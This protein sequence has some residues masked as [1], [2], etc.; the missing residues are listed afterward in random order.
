MGV[1]EICWVIYLAGLPFSNFLNKSLDLWHGH[2]TW[3]EIWLPVLVG[4]TFWSPTPNRPPN[5]ALG[6][7]I[8]V[9]GVT[10][11]GLWYVL[12]GQAKAYPVSLLMPMLHL[13]SALLFVWAAWQ[14]WTRQLVPILLTW[15][16]RVG[17][18]SVCYGL[19]QVA[20]LDQFF[21][22]ISANI[23]RDALVGTIGNYNHFA[24]Y[25]AML[26]PIFLW[27]KHYVWV[28]LTLILLALTRSEAGYLAAG[29]VG[30]WEAWG[31]NRRVFYGL[32]VLLIG[33]A[34][35][36]LWNTDGK[37]SLS[38]ASRLDKWGLYWQMASQKFIT[39]NGAGFIFEYAKVVDETH[40]THHPLWHW[41]HAHNEYLQLL[42]EQG[43]LGLV[44]FGWLVVD[45]GQAAWRLRRIPEVRVCAGM[46]LAI[47]SNALFNFP[48]HLWMLSSLGLMAYCGI[49]VIEAESCPS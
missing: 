10:T 23:G 33:T 21:K 47:L 45:A 14:S 19:V 38:L 29:I 22:P 44:A 32:L 49:K 37:L 9:V 46:L 43:L 31:S 6:T 36:L 40:E 17:M 7:W 1:R 41:R 16:G 18:V 15:I 2:A 3:A 35:F 24:V 4:L 5:K 25:L 28:G 27:K 30:L 13:L 34:G 20:N 42:V 8:A 48:F 11:V 26:L 12:A 39:G